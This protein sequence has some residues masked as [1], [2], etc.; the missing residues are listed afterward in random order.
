MKRARTKVLIFSDFNP[1][2]KDCLEESMNKKLAYIEGLG[3]EIVCTQYIP[4]SHQFIVTYR[5]SDPNV[6]TPEKW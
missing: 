4:A 3:C 6:E 2:M 5:S 1:S